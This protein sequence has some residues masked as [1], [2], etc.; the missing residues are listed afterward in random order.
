MAKCYH[1][2]TT[3]YG[4]FVATLAGMQHEQPL[5]I[6][7]HSLYLADVHLQ[8]QEQEKIHLNKLKETF[9]QADTN[10]MDANR[11][12]LL[13]ADLLKP[14]KAIKLDCF[15]TLKITPFRKI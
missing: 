12:E 13:E 5:L 4:G 7:E 10:E 14:Q 8:L 15:I 6:T 1:S 2:H 3:G 11:E 9:D